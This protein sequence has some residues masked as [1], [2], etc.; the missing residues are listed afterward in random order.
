MVED[1]DMY[2]SPLPLDLTWPSGKGE[3]SGSGVRQGREQLPLF[4]T[5]KNTQLINNAN[6]R[7]P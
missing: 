1:E 4:I 5:N 2:T 3:A 6:R 7:F